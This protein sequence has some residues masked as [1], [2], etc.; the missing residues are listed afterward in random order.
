ME[1]A[2]RA[3]TAAGLTPE[4][5]QVRG[6][7]DGARLS[8]MGLP[9]PNLGYGGY[10]AHGEREYIH[11]ESMAQMVQVILN[12]ITAFAGISAAEPK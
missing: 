7:T 1:I 5:S 2:I 11:L 3:M 8:F 10:N 9:C 4:I 12:I 6:G